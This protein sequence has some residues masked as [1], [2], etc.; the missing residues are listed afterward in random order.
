MKLL[1]SIAALI[2][3]LLLAPPGGSGEDRF[4]R[5]NDFGMLLARIAAYQKGDTRWVLQIRRS[6]SDEVRR[7]FD[8]GVEV[9]TWEIT[10]NKEHT[11]RVEREK[12]HDV[13]AAR[14]V[15]D[16][17]G[18]L[19]QDEEYTAGALSTKTLF[20]YAGGRLARTRTLAG[21]DGQ[22]VSSEAYLYASSG[23]LREVKRTAVQG[24]SMVSSAVTS[25]AGLSEERST[26]GASL[27]VER[28]DARGRVVSRERREDGAAVSTE[29]FSYDPATGTLVSSEEKL[30]LEHAQ[31]ARLYDGEGRL[32]RE[33]RS[34]N[35]SPQLTVGYER[36]AK[37]N[38]TMKTS[39]GA[40]GSESWKY[41]YTEKGD[42]SREEYYQKGILVKVTIPG[43]GK[44]RAEELYQDGEIFLKVYYDGD[45]RLREEVY[46]H[47]VLQR[48]RSY[49]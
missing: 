12:A 9:K 11:E 14:R 41:A 45:T 26:M 18:S 49:P 48:E 43:E 17:A 21:A 31:V 35:G 10:W 23:G 40:T 15:Y 16:A 2:A 37:G 6:G 20:T 36:D 47:G 46:L 8:K 28:Y 19:L 44:L 38:V 39:R 42:R 27:F 33:T 25:G 1:V 5:S 24:E 22:P 34:V 7:L 3:V 13:L 29:D 30:P 32:S 4:Y